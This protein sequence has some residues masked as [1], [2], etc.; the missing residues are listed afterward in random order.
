MEVGCQCIMQCHNNRSYAG[1][2]PR[3]GAYLIDKICVAIIVG[4]VAGVMGILSLLG[5]DFITKEKVLFQYTIFAIVLYVVEKMYFICFTTSTSQTPGKML[6]RIKIVN[7]DGSKASFWN[8]LYREVIGR[9]LAGLPIIAYA[10]YLMIIPDQEKRGLHDRLCDTRVIYDEQ[11][12]H[13]KTYDNTNKQ[14]E[15]NRLF[16]V[17][18]VDY[19]EE[20]VETIIQSAEEIQTK[21]DDMSED[22]NNIINNVSDKEL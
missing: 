12:N 20:T 18:E 2:A 16:N 4:M 10:G 21:I 1:A 6:F 14:D 13:E 15:I 11:V 9:F 5:L 8:I 19:K 3:I 17:N 22:I 7:E